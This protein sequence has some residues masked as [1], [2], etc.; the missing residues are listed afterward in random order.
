MRSMPAHPEPRELLPS[1]PAATA[2]G[3]LIA[4][5]TSEDA[6]PSLVEALSPQFAQAVGVDRFAA[7]THERRKKLAPLTVLGADVTDAR[8]VARLRARDGSLWVAHAVV[9]QEPPHKIVS[10]AVLPWVPEW[11]AP[12]LPLEFPASNGSSGR[13]ASAGSAPILIVVAGVPGSGKSTTAQAVGAEL[14]LPV[15]SIDWMMGALSPFGLRHSDDLLAIGEEILTTLA[16]RELQAGRSVVLDAPTESPETRQR[17]QSLASSSDA[18]FLAVVCRC[19][20]PQLHRERVEGRQRAI[21]GWADAGVWSDV[22]ARQARFPA[23]VGGALEIDTLAP[24]DQC[25]A[26]VVER[27][28]METN[29]HAET[30]AQRASTN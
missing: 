25:T 11:L 10:T 5:L 16:F 21:P 26:L 1:T 4:G 22:Q 18:R 7:I 24:L 2:L 17:W 19:S 14:G 9:Q 15:F 20:D 23:W 27:A 13:T 8:A 29:G 30:P 6:V 3:A 28:A 12:R